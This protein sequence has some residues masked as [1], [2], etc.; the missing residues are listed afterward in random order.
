[1]SFIR[2]EQGRKGLDGMHVAPQPH[3]DY[4]LR[5]FVP[6]PSLSAAMRASSLSYARHSGPT[7][8]TTANAAKAMLPFDPPG[9]L[10]LAGSAAH[11]DPAR[12]QS[13]SYTLRQRCQDVLRAA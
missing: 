8:A 6:L 1:M 7:N 10:L 2:S 4:D 9:V 13:C 5:P 3:L 11:E 12:G